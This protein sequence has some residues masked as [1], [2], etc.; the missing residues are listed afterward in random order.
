[1]LT[2]N[3]YSILE[4]EAQQ[5]TGLSFT[6]EEIE[7]CRTDPDFALVLGMPSNVNCNLWCKFCFTDTHNNKRPQL[8]LE[9]RMK[10]LDEA[11][12]VG[13]RTI[14][15]GG[16]GEPF[17]DRD[18][19]TILESATSRGFRYIIFTNL[20]L[21][22]PQRA[23]WLRSLPNVGIFGSAHS[24][25]QEIYEG[26]TQMPGSFARMMRGAH[27][28]LEAGF[29]TRDFAITT[30]VCKSNFHEI[31]DIVTY[32]GE[33]QIMVY[34]E[35]CNI[36]GY[37]EGFRDELYAP[38]EDFVALRRELGE[39][40]PGYRAEAPLV[41]DSRKCFT[42]EYA[43]IVSINGDVKTCFDGGEKGYIGNINEMT[44]REAV[45]RKY[46]NPC[47]C[48]GYD[49]CLNRNLFLVQLGKEPLAQ[50]GKAPLATA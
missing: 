33:R 23:A 50:L 20:T 8:T 5:F 42:G 2:E 43:V 7:R 6:A 31:D 10:L 41:T 46:A 14:I 27:N 34:P 49:H 13:I 48:K 36:T 38:Y 4:S 28:L 30:V 32:W 35:Y 19:E 29:T 21:I 26:I 44:L 16:S 25:D 22:T 24:L 47:F 40:H 12:E 37:A 39:R 15:T 17:S 45:R 11:E 9:R 3:L 18:F 1:M